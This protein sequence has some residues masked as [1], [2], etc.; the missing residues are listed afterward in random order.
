MRLVYDLMILPPYT[1][2]ALC[3]IKEHIPIQNV[4]FKAGS[5]TLNTVRT[6]VIGEEDIQNSIQK[7]SCLLSAPEMLQHG[8]SS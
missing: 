8:K 1:G 5:F 4:S 3:S 6:E 2:L 7:K